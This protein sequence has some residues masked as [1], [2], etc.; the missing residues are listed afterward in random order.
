MVRTHHV[1]GHCRKGRWVRPHYR[2][3]PAGRSVGRG[4]RRQT[5]GAVG[6][7]V[8]VGIAVWAAA[9]A[10]E[11]MVAH[12]WIIAL[13]IAI[14]SGCWAVVHFRS[15]ADRRTARSANRVP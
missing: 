8:L 13:M 6:V 14:P 10:L 11:W 15:G 4:G 5:N 12:W 7:L 2:K 9:K 1:R 3:N